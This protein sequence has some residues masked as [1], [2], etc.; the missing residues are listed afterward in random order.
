MYKS[1]NT[2]YFIFITNKTTKFIP[3]AIN[4][5]PP[6]YENTSLKTISITKHQT[7]DSEITDKQHLSARPNGDRENLLATNRNK[8]G[9]F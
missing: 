1:C 7:S 2:S 8:N 9:R 6:S 5:P 3:L 4:I